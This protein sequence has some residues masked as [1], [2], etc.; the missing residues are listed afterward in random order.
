MRIFLLG[1]E[2]YHYTIYGIINHLLILFHRLTSE[3]RV[4]GEELGWAESCAGG[5]NAIVAPIFANIQGQDVI[6]DGAA[7]QGAEPTFS[8]RGAGVSI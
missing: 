7:G 4:Y 8:S 1:L 3:V 6:E 5:W 2:N